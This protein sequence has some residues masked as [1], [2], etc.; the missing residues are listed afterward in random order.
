MTTP[1]L[2]VYAE[3]PEPMYTREGVPLCDDHC[4]HHDGK[5]CRMMGLSAREGLPCQ[6]AVAELVAELEETKGELFKL[7]ELLEAGAKAGI[8]AMA[9]AFGTVLERAYTPPAATP[10]GSMRDLAPK[11]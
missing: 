1:T 3:A 9:T 5:R 4:R 10:V 7:R 8:H 11:G 2:R 6:P